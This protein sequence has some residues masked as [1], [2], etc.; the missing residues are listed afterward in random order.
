VV[1]GTGDIW[2]VELANRAA[3]RKVLSEETTWSARPE[4][5]P[6]G[7]RILYS[8]YH[9]R[10]WHQLWLTTPAG[11]APLPLTFGE[12]DRRNA[13]W[14]PDGK[15]IAY[16]SNE[17]GGTELV[18]QRV[19]GGDTTVVRP[20]ERLY[21]TQRGLLEIDAATRK[22]ARCRFASRSSRAISV[23]TRPTTAGCTPTMASIAGCSAPRRTIFTARRQCS[24]SVPAGPAQV[25]VRRGFRYTP[26]QQSIRVDAG[27]TAKL[28]PAL[29]LNELPPEF[30]KWLS[31]DL[32]VHMNYG[33][34]YRNTPQHLVEQARA[35]DL[36]VVRT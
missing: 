15:Q 23:R 19:V 30:G 31:A 12:F 33:G 11:A 14:S 18:V 6:D 22:A 7:H 10:Q 5:S 35:E 36:D 3:P 28:V 16:I 26:L 2:T 27:R 20:T 1:W 4:P 29:R 34:H 24:V 9:G 17:H 32:H 25:T 13:R 21:R 8:S